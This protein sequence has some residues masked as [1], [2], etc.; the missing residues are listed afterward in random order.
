[1]RRNLTPGKS[2]QSDGDYVVLTYIGKPVDAKPRLQRGLEDPAYAKKKLAGPAAARK[3]APKEFSEMEDK[4]KL[5]K[6]CLE[7]L[8]KQ[9]LSSII[10]SFSNSGK[11]AQLKMP[12]PSAGSSKTSVKE[13]RTFLQTVAW[14]NIKDTT[15]RILQA[16]AAAREECL[17]AANAAASQAQASS[18]S[19]FSSSSSAAAAAAG[20]NT[21]LS[22][23]AK[24]RAKPLPTTSSS[25]SSSSSSA[26]AAAAPVDPCQPSSTAT[27]RAGRASNKRQH[28]QAL[29]RETAAEAQRVQNKQPPHCRPCLHHGLTAGDASPHSSCTCPTAAAA[30]AE[31]QQPG[32]QQFLQPGVP[33]SHAKFSNFRHVACNDPGVNSLATVVLPLREG[34]GEGNRSGHGPRRNVAGRQEQ[35]RLNPASAASNQRVKVW[36]LTQGH[37]DMATGKARRLRQSQAHDRKVAGQ[38]AELSRVTRNTTRPERLGSYTAVLGAVVKERKA[39]RTARCVRRA[40]FTYFM[41]AT[42]VMDSFWASVLKGHPG[43]LLAYGD[44]WVGGGWPGQGP[45]RRMFVSAQRVLGKQNT[46]LEKEYN[47]SQKHW[48]CGAQLQGVVDKTKNHTK[49]VPEGA[50]EDSLK[51]CTNTYC[52]NFVDRDVNAALNILLAFMARLKVRWPPPLCPTP[53]PIC[54][55]LL[56]CQCTHYSNATLPS[57]C[58]PSRPA[59]AGARAQCRPL[60]RRAARAPPRA[61]GGARCARS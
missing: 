61:S 51:R 36:R 38:N 60:R 16:A 12:A 32:L 46:V 34:E 45:H 35:R 27:C 15:N 48:F 30:A 29:E 57:L 53:P 54:A 59:A 13:L 6:K 18:S 24:K 20:N 19:S 56:P 10:T 2:F 9:E 58:T 22:G 39:N 23:P 7:W 14:N 33:R 28:R 25:S 55:S 47:T 31:Q 26:A 5:T 44:G 1:M 3:E 50:L 40:R 41:R 37:Y 52:L 21:T 42:S 11:A 4:G 43:L 17:K 8:N 49:N